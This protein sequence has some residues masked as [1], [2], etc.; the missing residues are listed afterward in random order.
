MITRLDF[1][2]RLREGLQKLPPE[3][4]E[5]AVRYYT[6]YFDDAGAENEEKVLLELGDPM[7][8]A[9][10]ITAEYL[11][12][13]IA[14]EE[15][16]YTSQEKPTG[17]KGLSAVWVA[18]LAVFASPIALPIAIAIAVLAFSLVIV[19]ASMLFAFYAVA[20]AFVLAGIFAV[21]M[22]FVSLAVDLLTGLC[23]IGTGLFFVGL[24]LI[25]FLPLL[26]LTRVTFSEIAR[27]IGRR[28]VGR[29]KL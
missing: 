2:L 3:E 14:P 28:A 22:G 10:Q 17:K 7:K 25:T 9:Q 6:E 18:I 21:V 8:I 13:G 16:T 15:P 26:Q 4:L 19:I 27:L 1:F 20:V 23:A 5:T 12:R 29:K 11:V 24:G